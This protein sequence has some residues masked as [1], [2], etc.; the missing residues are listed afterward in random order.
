MIKRRLLALT[1]AVESA[2]LFPVAYQPNLRFDYIQT[3]SRWFAKAVPP[4]TVFI[5]DSIISS[6]MQF[7]SLRTINL[8]S[9]GLQTYQVV[10]LLPKARSFRPQHIAIM[11]G[12]NDAGEGPIDREELIGLW[13]Q[14]C[15]EPKIVI[16]L[17]T[18]T[19]IDYLNQRIDQIDQIILGVCT[20]NKI[21]NLRQLA[22]G[23]GKIYPKYTVDGVHLSP[24]AHAIWRSELR[25]FGI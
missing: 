5:G 24:E 6:G 19:A 7:H 22:D 16:T 17:P 23:K 3:L 8:G 15:A 18:P 14:I 25:R 21:I 10:E 11:A 9:S 1:L 12:T 2:L 4:E 13:K 20:K